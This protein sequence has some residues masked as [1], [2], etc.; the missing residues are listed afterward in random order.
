[1]DYDPHPVILWEL[2]RACDLNCR[3][4]TLGAVPARDPNELT[5]YEA[6]KTV[7]QIASLAPRELAITGGDP[8]EREDV[9][10][11][12]DYARRRG[13]D[14][15][16][17][18]SPTSKLTRDAILRLKQMGLTRVV[19]SLD[20]ST[21]RIHDAI[22]GVPGVFADTLRAIDWA[23]AAGLAVEI[24]TLMTRR[25]GSDLPV[26]ASLFRHLRIRRWNLYFPVP[27]GSA[28][29]DPLGADDAE[30]LFP[31]IDEIRSQESYA[32]RVVEGPHYRR[33]RMQRSL[34]A[35]LDEAAQ[36]S[37]ADFEGYDWLRQCFETG[38]PLD[39]ARD[40]A[41]GFVFISHAGDVRASEFL[42]L[43]AG[44]LRYRDLGAI[45]RGSDLFQALRNPDNLKGRCGRCEFRRVC[46]GSRARAWA[47]SGDAFGDDPL[48]N[49]EPGA[50][51]PLP[52]IGR[53]VET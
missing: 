7:D 8:L 45:Y 28:R 19:F 26:M 36:V 50:P 37:W 2:T 31:V 3:N 25:S 46:G 44:N 51:M 5:T 17:V 22:H 11:I 47:V 39:A 53:P 34:A 52:V 40:G 21:A 20:G 14:P 35:K 4:C 10:Q 42:P 33:H 23:V 6:Y 32:V 1:M 43:S 27:L 24:N 18:V 13:L 15:A 49:W 16:V 29:F 41:R 38:D 12:L 30:K 9:G 48:C